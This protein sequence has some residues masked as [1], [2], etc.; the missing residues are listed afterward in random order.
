MLYQLGDFNIDIFQVVRHQGVP[1]FYFEILD[2]S[3]DLTDCGIEFQ[4]NTPIQTYVL[5]C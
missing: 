5:H 2:L 1:L 3:S 4:I